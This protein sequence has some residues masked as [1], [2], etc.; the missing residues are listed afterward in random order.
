[1][2]GTTQALTSI[3][4]SANGS[5][6]TNQAARSPTHEVNQDLFLKLMVAQLRHQNPLK[7]VDGVDFLAQLSQVS[8]VEQMVE[9]NRELKSIHA[10]LQAGA[11]A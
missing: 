4:L 9:M 1:M 8:C 11:K 2:A 7:P 10:L 3:S 6:G 5:Q